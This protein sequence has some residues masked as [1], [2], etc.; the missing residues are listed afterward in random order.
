MYLFKLK[1]FFALYIVRV[2]Y[3]GLLISDNLIIFCLEDLVLIFFFAVKSPIKYSELKHRV[4][5]NACAK[6]C[7][8]YYK[9]KMEKSIAFIQQ[10]L[11][12]LPTRK[13][14]SMQYTNCHDILQIVIEIH[15]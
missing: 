2:L 4:D 7:I 9:F 12:G 1:K 11:R 6:K 14:K 3:R 10:Q 13:I 15:L 5:A 8:Q